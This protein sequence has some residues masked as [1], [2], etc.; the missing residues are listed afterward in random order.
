MKSWWDTCLINNQLMK[1]ISLA[2]RR[3]R[4]LQD[5]ADTDRFDKAGEE[6][7]TIKRVR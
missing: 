4:Q 5:E 3:G 2:L 7:P 1:R 6:A